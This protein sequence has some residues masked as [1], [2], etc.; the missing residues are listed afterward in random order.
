MMSD[1]TIL[2]TGAAGFIGFHVARRLLAEGRTVV[3]LDSL[4]AYYDPQFSSQSHGFRPERGCHTAFCE[5]D[6]N[7]SATTWFIEGD[8]AACFDRLDHGVWLEILR[9]NIHDGRFINLINEL[10][11]A[12][13]MEEWT[14]NDVVLNDDHG[15][16][17][18]QNF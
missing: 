16:T 11:K 2:V 14:Y 13:Y 17:A 18:C 1:Q 8:S 15:F 4:N 10:L 5:I 12:G 3:G 7:W 6:Q 9:E